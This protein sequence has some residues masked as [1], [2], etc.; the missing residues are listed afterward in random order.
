[1]SISGVGIFFANWFYGGLSDSPKARPSPPVSAVCDHAVLLPEL[2]NLEKQFQNI[3]FKDMNL[4]APLQLLG[5]MKVNDFIIPNEGSPQYILPH[6]DKVEEQGILVCTGTQRSLFNLCLGADKYT[7]L[8][9]RDINP[10]VKAYIDFIVL[11]LRLSENREEYR[12]LSELALP[13]SY[14][15]EDRESLTKDKTKAIKHKLEQSASIPEKAK[16]YYL[17]NFESFADIYFSYENTAFFGWKT[18]PNYAEVHYHEN[19]RLFKILQD[20]AKSGRIMA[21]AGDINDLR[22]LDSQK[23]A[24]VDVSNISDYSLIDLQIGTSSRPRVI[25]TIQSPEKTGFYSYTHKPLTDKQRK[26]MTQLIQIIMKTRTAA[27]PDRLA[28][29]LTDIFPDNAGKHNEFDC[30]PS[31]S[32]TEETLKKLR[33]FKEKFLLEISKKKW[34]CLCLVCCNLEYLELHEIQILSHHP[35]ISNFVKVLVS[36]WNTLPSEKY[37]AFSEVPGWQEAFQDEQK[38]DNSFFQSYLRKHSQFI[39][40]HNIPLP[41]S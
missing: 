32:F 14:S 23:I 38:K 10:K 15:K 27:N 26:E 17:K 11:L 8:V 33:L 25:W 30:P 40:P 5:G 4:D 13:K 9:V 20:H 24:V 39:T 35:L 7:G 1:M 12:Q 16:N 34:A 3:C 2:I 28:T 41:V 36:L 19:D 22:F 6:L 18:D 29:D 31:A 21:A 37:F